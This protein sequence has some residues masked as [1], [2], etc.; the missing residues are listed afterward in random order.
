MLH[1]CNYALT[2]LWLG[3][4]G[5]VTPPSELSKLLKNDCRY[6]R[7]TYDTLFSINLAFSGKSLGEIHREIFK[8]M[9][10]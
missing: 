10:F 4:G 6:R 5:R 7:K 8:K 3:G 9:V 2:R 1:I